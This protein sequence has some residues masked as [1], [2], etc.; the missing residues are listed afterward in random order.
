MHITSAGV[1][2]AKDVFS[3][4]AMGERQAIEQRQLKRDALRQWLSHLPPGTFVGMEACGTC[5]YWAREMVSL[6]LQ[7]RIMA[8]EFVAPYRKSRAMKNDRNDAEAIALAVVSPGMR[9]VAPKTLEQQ[10]RLSLHRMREGWKEER[11]ALVNRLR[12]LLME[13]GLVYPRSTAV[14]R[15]GLVCAMH[16]EQLPMAVR[17]F[18][19]WAREDLQRLDERIASCDRAIGLACR[20]DPAARRLRELMGVGPTTADAV[21]ATVGSAREFRNGRQ[22]AAW[23]GLVPRQFTTGGKPKLGAITK[24]GDA[25][26]RTLLI[27]GAKSVLK[28]ALRVDRERATRLQLWISE[29]H[30]RAGYHKALVAIA[31]KNARILWALLAKDQT[32]NPDAW[33]EYTAA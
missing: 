32:Y 15:K 24:R 14:L 13:F 25:Y 6:G 19:R 11:T 10:G 21:L 33:K 9:F 2:L 12:G 5:H 20:G 23:L 30:A 29:L 18:L 17:E 7:P 31:N 4:C 27:Q 26:V 16:D 1:D 3:V 8:A 28:Q 22:F